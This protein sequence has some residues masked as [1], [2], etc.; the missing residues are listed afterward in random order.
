MPRRSKHSSFR[1]IQKQFLP[2]NQAPHQDPGEIALPETSSNVSASH[3]KLESNS[4]VCNYNM[5]T[6]ISESEGMQIGVGYCLIDLGCLNEAL[7]SLHMCED[8]KYLFVYIQFGLVLT[9]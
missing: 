7:A 2:K 6:N 5:D 4:N 9:L 3:R 8:G 1:G